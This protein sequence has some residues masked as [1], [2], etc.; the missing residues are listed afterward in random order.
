MS[1]EQQEHLLGIATTIFKREGGWWKAV[2][3]LLAIPM[4]VGALVATFTYTFVGVTYIEA[5]DYAKSAAPAALIAVKEVRDSLHTRESY[6][7]VS[8]LPIRK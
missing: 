4:I 8:P 7:F 5:I 6:S 2:T 1:A 3:V